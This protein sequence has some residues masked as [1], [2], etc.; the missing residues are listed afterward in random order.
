MNTF[1]DF[2]PDKVKAKAIDC[3]AEI[4]SDDDNK[5]I[6]KIEEFKQSK[7]M[8]SSS[9]CIA[10]DDH[11]F[12]SYVGEYNHQYFIYDFNKDSSD[13]ESMIGITLTPEIE[14]EA[15]HL[16]NDDAISSDQKLTLENIAII[17]K[18]DSSWYHDELMR[19]EKKSSLSK[20]MKNNP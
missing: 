9:W 12:K 3:N 20:A 16:K 15:A 7:I 6:I 18:N 11:Y 19:R 1:S 8:G 5:L 17:V 10:R 2:T 4:I 13:N 14:C